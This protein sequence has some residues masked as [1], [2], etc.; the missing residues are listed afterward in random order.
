MR[1]ASRASGA[2]LATIAALAVGGCALI[3]G[4]RVTRVPADA[5]S[6]RTSVSV[7]AAPGPGSAQPTPPGMGIDCGGRPVVL[8]AGSP[9]FTLS[10][11]CPDVQV[12]GPDL[13]VDLTSASVQSL[14]VGGD[15]VT[16]RAGGIADVT[17]QGNDTVVS[18]TGIEALVVR[19]DRN[20]VIS[21]GGVGSVVVQG[22]DNTVRG[23]VGR[24][25]DEGGRNTIG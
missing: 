16:V 19:G 6:P 12:Q 21:S 20:A 10:G 17:V 14:L 5:P 23:G 9:S 13:A 2:A 7:T 11:E 22:N 3:P 24:M 18:A 25:S 1:T 4:P 8:S 15:R